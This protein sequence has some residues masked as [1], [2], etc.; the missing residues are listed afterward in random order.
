MWTLRLPPGGGRYLAAVERQDAL[1]TGELREAARHNGTLLSLGVQ[2]CGLSTEAEAAVREA[3]R[4]P[5][6]KGADLSWNDRRAVAATA[7]RLRQAVLNVARDRE[8]TLPRAPKPPRKAGKSRRGVVGHN[9]KNQNRLGN[10]AQNNEN[11][12]PIWRPK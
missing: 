9:N 7:G 6:L 11:R 2:G 1:V 12:E 4:A 8:L 3:V 5:P 10:D